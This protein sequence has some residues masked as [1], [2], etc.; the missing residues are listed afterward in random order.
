VGGIEPATM[1]SYVAAGA[2]GFGLGSAVYKPGLT[3]GEVGQR[4]ATFVEAW[5]AL[6][7]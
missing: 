1:A 2:K 5:Q 7:P 4:A 3:P 6:R